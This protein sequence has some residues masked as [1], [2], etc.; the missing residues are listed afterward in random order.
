MLPESPNKINPKFLL[1][2]RKN[3][4]EAQ[5]LSWSVPADNKGT[6]LD[7]KHQTK[8]I[9]HGFLD[10]QL[11]GKWMQTLKDEFLMLGQFNVII[12]DWSGGNGLPYGQATVNTRVVGAVIANLIKSLGVICNL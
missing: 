3:P 10:N 1:Y 2:T 12:V 6:N 9:I 4:K 5:R 7:P 8:L 11:F